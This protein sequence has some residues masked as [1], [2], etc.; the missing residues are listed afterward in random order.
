M[1]STGGWKLWQRSEGRRRSR[2]VYSARL[3][4]RAMSV[5]GVRG[6][7]SRI[8]KERSI[9]PL[10]RNSFKKLGNLHPLRLAPYALRPYQG[11]GSPAPPDVR[12]WKVWEAFPTAKELRGGSRCGLSPGP[13]G[14]S[15]PPHRCSR[16]NV[17][18]QPARAPSPLRACQGVQP[19][20]LELQSMSQEPS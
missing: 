11:W 10:T 14:P 4:S 8:R 12:W 15:C 7:G 20:Q 9:V 13:P 5:A 3:H 19:Q 18:R 17:F 16:E 1:S 6:R 2:V